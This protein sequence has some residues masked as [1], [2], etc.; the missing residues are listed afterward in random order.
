MCAWVVNNFQVKG[1]GRTPYRSIWSKDYT[2]E[3]VPFGDVCLGRNFSEDG[4]KWIWGVFVGKRDR[5]DEFLLL[6]PTDA[7]KTRCVRRL[8]GDNCAN[9]VCVVT[10]STTAEFQHN[11]MMMRTNVQNDLRHEMALEMWI[12]SVHEKSEQLWTTKRNWKQSVH[13]H[14]SVLLKSTS[15]SLHK[16]RSTGM[17]HTGSSKK[18][19]DFLKVKIRDVPPLNRGFA[20]FCS[21]TFCGTGIFTSVISSTIWVTG[22]NS[23]NNLSNWNIHLCD[24]FHNLCNWNIYDLLQFS[25]FPI[26]AKFH[27]LKHRLCVLHQPRCI[28]HGSIPWRHSTDSHKS[29]CIGQKTTNEG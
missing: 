13:V 14:R 6:T 25:T 1:S 5:T 29:H 12:V 18:N 23:V 2:G 21:S 19:F 26:N 9:F 27:Q 17:F 8:E 28:R 15:L 24:L 20:H 4:A 16:I 3:V 11:D 22:T 10:R 7:M